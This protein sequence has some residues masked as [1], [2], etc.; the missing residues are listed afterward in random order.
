MNIRVGENVKAKLT[1]SV[2]RG[3]VEKAKNLGLNLSQCFENCLKLYIQAIENTNQKIASNQPL[4]KKRE[5]MET[6]GCHKITGGVGFEPT[7]TSLGGLRPIHARPPA[8]IREI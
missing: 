3:I 6:E 1:L 4:N 5:G 7:I 8:L 2:E